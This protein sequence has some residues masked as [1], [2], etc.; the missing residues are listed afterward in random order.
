MNLFE[1]FAKLSLDTSDYDKGLDESQGK[2]KDFGKTLKSGFVG[3]TKVAAAGVTAL[4]GGIT[5]GVAALNSIAGATEE[6]RVAMGKLGT[7]FESVGMS[8]ETA[9]Q[10]YTEFYKILGDTD[11]AT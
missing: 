2:A 6:Y 4:A 1:V 9:N 3:A 10:A 11:T 8:Q 5:A 7:A